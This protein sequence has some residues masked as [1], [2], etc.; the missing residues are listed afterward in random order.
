MVLSRS[1]NQLPKVSVIIPSYNHAAHL[2]PCVDSVLAQSYPHCEI[3]VVDDGSTDESVAILQSYGNAIRLIRQQNQGTQAARNRAIRASSGDYLALLDS[4]DA[5][6]P[7]KLARQMAAFQCNPEAGLVY[8]L[9]YRV[10]EDDTEAKP[11]SRLLGRPL[12][13]D[14]RLAFRQL[15]TA[16]R[17][18]AL[19]A[20]FPRACID[21]YGYFDETLLGAG[22][23]DMWL[24]IALHRPIVC[25]PEPL[26]LYRQHATN[27]TKAL[28]QTRRVFEEHSR[29]LDKV[30]RLAPDGLLPPELKDKALAQ[31][32]LYGAS[33]AAQV[34]DAA[35]T[36]DSLAKALAR[37]PALT[38]DADALLGP[39]VSCTH[40]LCAAEPTAACYRDFID[41]LFARLSDVAPA[42]A[43]LRDE[44]LARATMSTVFAR[45]QRGQR[46]G[47][48]SLL[49]TGIRAKPRWLF[50]LGVL[51]IGLRAA[52]RTMLRRSTTDDV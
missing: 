38:T 13:D 14:R 47:L 2:R 33:T 34:G 46:G 19:T 52:L 9:A 20:V 12:A 1:L 49:W 26:A 36:I 27:T 45:Y 42:A 7:D 51:S 25:V 31:T 18:P 6:L 5:W 40:Q 24:R 28:F 37:D 11:D 8:S 22:D 29:V 32:A 43:Q 50:N 48:G 41:L 30:F 4:D 35:G 44:A 3:V 16:N 21:A 10:G 15:V 17:I 39:I 23:W